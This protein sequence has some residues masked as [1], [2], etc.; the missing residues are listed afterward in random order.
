LGNSGHRFYGALP[1]LSQP[2]NLSGDDG[3]QTVT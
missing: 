3:L 1:D 2:N